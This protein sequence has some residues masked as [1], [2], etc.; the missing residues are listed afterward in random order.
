MFEEGTNKENFSEVS[1]SRAAGHG[2]LEQRLVETK[3]SKSSEK[4]KKGISRVKMMTQQHKEEVIVKINPPLCHQEAKLT[5]ERRLNFD[6]SQTSQ[7]VQSMG[8]TFI[9]QTTNP[10]ER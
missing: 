10:W 2:Y 9:Q 8:N 5:T 1:N 3:P 4:G 7:Y 6:S